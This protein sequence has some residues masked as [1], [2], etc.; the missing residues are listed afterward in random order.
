MVMK[1]ALV[2][3][4][5]KGKEKQDYFFKNQIPSVICHIQVLIFISAPYKVWNISTISR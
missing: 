1:M 2:F 4:K 5:K 3:K